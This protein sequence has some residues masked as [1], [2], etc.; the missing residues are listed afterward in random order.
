MD[1]IFKRSTD[2]NECGL[3]W[4]LTDHDFVDASNVEHAA[5]WYDLV[6]LEVTM[7]L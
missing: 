7:V 1:W 3:K 2:G 5:L 6:V 4:K